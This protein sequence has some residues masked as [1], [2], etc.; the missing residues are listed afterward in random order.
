MCYSCLKTEFIKTNK[1]QKTHY[2]DIQPHSE[3]MGGSLEEFKVENTDFSYWLHDISRVLC[4][5]LLN[6]I[7]LLVLEGC[8]KD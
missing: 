2:Q 6:K 4:P 1:Q 8:G 3:D 5:S 7:K